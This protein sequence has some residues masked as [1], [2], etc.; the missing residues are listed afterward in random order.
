MGQTGL[1]L[2]LPQN[3]TKRS[4]QTGLGHYPLQHTEDIYIHMTKPLEIEDQAGGH[5]TNRETDRQTDRG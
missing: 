4:L 1:G 5:Q 3:P 2:V